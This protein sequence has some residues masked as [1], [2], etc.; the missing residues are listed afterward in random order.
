MKGGIK[1]KI[2]LLFLILFPIPS[3]SFSDLKTEYQFKLNTEIINDIDNVHDG[4]SSLFKGR[5]KKGNSAKII[6]I[7]KYF[8]N[9]IRLSLKQRYFINKGRYDI[10]LKSNAVSLGEITSAN[11]V[12]NYDIEQDIYGKFTKFSLKFLVKTNHRPNIRTIGDVKRFFPDNYFLNEFDSKIELRHKVEYMYRYESKIIDNDDSL[13]VSIDL[14]F[15]KFDSDDLKR[16]EISYRVSSKEKNNTYM[17]VKV[18]SVMKNFN[19]LSHNY[20]ITAPED[21]Y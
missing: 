2:F 11:I 6:I 15:D 5:Y 14:Y 10:I 3:Y 9:N 18:Y 17:A 8:V 16:G 7:K 12:S 21:Y 4:L 1:L 20:Q 13:N 19:L